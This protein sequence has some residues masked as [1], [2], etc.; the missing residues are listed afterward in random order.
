MSWLLGAPPK[1]EL[2]TRPA[3]G[4]P[5]FV[6]VHGTGA[7]KTF[8]SGWA[9]EEGPLRRMLRSVDS[10]AGL[11]VYEWSGHNRLTARH[12]AAE[13]LAKDAQ[14]L[15]STF[16]EKL[17]AISHSHG[18][19]VV[20][21]SATDTGCWWSAVYVNTPFFTF[22]DPSIYVLFA[23]VVAFPAGVISMLAL[24]DWALQEVPRFFGGAPRQWPFNPNQMVAWL[25]MA[26]MMFPLLAIFQFQRIP[27]RSRRRRRV[28]H[29]LVL[30]VTN[31]EAFVGLTAFSGLQALLTAL[32]R[33][34]IFGGLLFGFLSVGSEVAGLTS[35]GQGVW[36]PFTFVAALLD[37]AF[38]AV[39][40]A[41]SLAYGPVQ[42][43]WSA[44]TPIV[45]TPAPYGRVDYL[46]VPTKKVACLRH[47]SVL[48]NRSAMRRVG[49]WLRARLDAGGDTSGRPGGYR[50]DS[51]MLCEAVYNSEE[52]RW[53]GHELMH[54]RYMPAGICS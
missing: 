11:A 32:L 1:M 7:R 26:A 25:A 43:L 3:E 24:I 12:A 27:N 34:L 30:Q 47:S 33:P 36:N 39:F 46:T 31:D 23:V 10:E 52:A 45:V 6:L 48:L 18:G 35:G 20:A 38:F 22:T 16:G 54:D 41:A 13:Q 21:W 2:I 50:E 29:E 53:A 42:A 8:R 49:L 14:L 44:M 4:H 40:L 17:I 19:N 37:T 51:E 15:H 5:I 28:R 9:K